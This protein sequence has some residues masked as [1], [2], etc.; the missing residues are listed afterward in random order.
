MFTLEEI[1]SLHQK[2][3]TGA[4][5]PQYARDLI[6]IGVTGYD[7]FVSDGHAKY[8]GN[9]TVLTSPPKYTPLEIAKMMNK[10]HFIERLRLHQSWGS[11]YMTFCQDCA[12]SGVEKWTLDMVA[13]TCTYYDRNGET[14][15]VEHF[16]E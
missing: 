14:L 15:I 7:T 2:V 4:D 8:F 12:S 13:R 11:D 9:P 16:P 5:F 1:A 10:E 6:D 3:K